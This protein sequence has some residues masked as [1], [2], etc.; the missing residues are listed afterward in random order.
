MSSV[1]HAIAVASGKGGVGKS[2]V[3]VN[4]AVALAQ[5]GAQVG[6]LDGDIYGPS[7]P[8]MTGLV[9]QHPH[10]PDGQRVSP[11]TSH[12]VKLMSMGFLVE[13]A[14]S[15]AFRGPVVHQ[16]IQEFLQDVDWGDLD[17]LT[18]DLPPGTGD[19]VITLIH[20]LPLSGVVIVSTPQ[21]LAVV[22]VVRCVALFRERE[23]PLLGV[24]ENMSVSLCPHCGEVLDIF[25]RGHKV[26]EMCAYWEIPFLGS[27]PLDSQV[28][29]SGDVGEPVVLRA[30]DSPASQALTQI[31]AELTARTGAVSETDVEQSGLPRPRIGS[32]SAGPSTGSGGSSGQA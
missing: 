18:V 29:E 21:N 3:A 17:Y 19:A 5:T 23:V 27:V 28:R 32:P 24:I 10:S 22:S 7:V 16:V 4:L 6:L 1:R 9:G 13:E 8:V 14:D 30:P 20:S 12:G 26:R 2:T 11:L 31:A 15:L 25:G